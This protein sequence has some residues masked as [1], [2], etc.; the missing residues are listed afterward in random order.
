MSREPI[1]RIAICALLLLAVT[2]VTLLQAENKVSKNTVANYFDTGVTGK[3]KYK[4]VFPLKWN[5]RVV[6]LAHGF[7]PAEKPLKADFPVQE[8]VYQKL[9]MDGW[10]IASTS[11]RRNGIIIRDAVE[12]ID[13]LRQYIVGKYGKPQRIIIVGESMGGIIGT[14]IAESQPA[15]YH[16]V[17]SLGMGRISLVPASEYKLTHAPEIPILFVSNQKE[18]QW[19]RE[20]IKAF[21]GKGSPPPLWHIKR[22]GHVNI[23][24]WEII[25]AFLALNNHIDT[26]KPLETNMDAT[27]QPKTGD[28]K[29]QF[30]D[31]GAYASITLVH[32]TYGNMDTEFIEADFKR[33]GIDRKTR[34]LLKFKDKEVTVYLGSAYSDVP[35]GHWVAAITGKGVVKIARNHEHAAKTLGCKAGD[36]V[37]IRKAAD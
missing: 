24:D 23:S 34:F 29:A 5:K 36:K 18:L 25:R 26:G 8:L 19:P 27:I 33:L 37:F 10:M 21:A 4:I 3:A 32:P 12:D 14:I 20:Y 9:L 2:G 1:R 17:L 6:M 11:Y 13:K 35:R 31:G 28:S 15:D 30:K 7:V 16:G 22:D